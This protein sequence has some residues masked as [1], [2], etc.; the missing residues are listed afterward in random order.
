MIADQ[1]GGSIVLISSTQ[2]LSGRGG[3]GTGW[4]T[5]YTSAKHGVVGLMRS[6]SHWLAPHNIRVNS[7]HPT[8]IPTD[9]TV[10]ETMDRILKAD[11]GKGDAFSNLMPVPMIEAMDVTNAITWLVS[12]DARY[13]TGVTLPVDAGFSVK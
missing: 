3:D 11:P 13:V 12:D 7:I 4:M 6:F 5:G 10:S 9:I 1:R 2:G 8:G